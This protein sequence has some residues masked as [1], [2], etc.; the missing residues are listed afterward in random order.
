MATLYS[1]PPSFTPQG[2]EG[3]WEGGWEAA[4]HPRGG[5]RKRGENGPPE[6]P[7]GVKEGGSEC[8]VA[9]FL[10][11]PLPTLGEGREAGRERI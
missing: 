11:S 8:K 2:W 4:S 9:I 5:K 7:W 3:G 10:P 6:L 1:L